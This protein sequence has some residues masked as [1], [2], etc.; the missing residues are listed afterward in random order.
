[1][2]CKD[3]G[4]IDNNPHTEEY[5]KDCKE[6]C[7]ECNNCKELICKKCSF[8]C[9]L[10]YESFCWECNYTEDQGSD[11]RCYCW[12]CGYFCDEQGIFDDSSV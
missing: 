12:D 3:C 6:F 4:G 1:M 2:E 11:P 9:E 10:C 5:C 7:K 8:E